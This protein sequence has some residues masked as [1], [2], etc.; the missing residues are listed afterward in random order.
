MFASDEFVVDWDAASDGLLSLGEE[1][2][3][4]TKYLDPVDRRFL[5]FIPS[6]GMM[7]EAIIVKSIDLAARCNAMAYKA[8]PQFSDIY[9]RLTSN[10]LAGWLVK[11]TSSL[12]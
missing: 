9:S 8:C 11:V 4:I 3:H 10:F 7:V 6:D 1:D 2:D 5:D 12:P